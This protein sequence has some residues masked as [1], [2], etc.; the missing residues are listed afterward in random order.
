MFGDISNW[1]FTDNFE[2]VPLLSIPRVSDR[3]LSLFV[4]N[5]DKP[6]LKTGFVNIFGAIDMMGGLDYHA[7]Q[8]TQACSALAH[9]SQL[10]H[11]AVYHEAVAYINRAGQFHAFAKSDFVAQSLSAPMEIIPSISR[12]MIFRNKHTA[13][14]SIDMPKQEETHEH[15]RHAQSLGSIGGRLFT[16]RPG[17]KFELNAETTKD[18]SSLQ[19]ELWENNYLTIN[20]WDGQSKSQ[21]NFTLEQE[22]PSIIK[23]AYTL[24]ER[25]LQQDSEKTT[26]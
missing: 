2:G 17:R 15:W 26:G 5:R 20:T 25:L 13:H 19:R 21:V 16:P 9:G 6:I 10:E 4:R 12:I 3:T 1:R 14:R 24:I 18:A 11:A 8:F 22:H 23:E 7:E